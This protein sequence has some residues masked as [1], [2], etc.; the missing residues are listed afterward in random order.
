LARLAFDLLILAALCK[1]LD[2]LARQGVLNT[3]MLSM[4]LVG[5]SFFLGMAPGEVG[6]VGVLRHPIR[7]LIRSGI[8]VVSLLI[9]W[10]LLWVSGAWWQLGVLYIFAILVYALGRW[11]GL[12]WK[13]LVT[14]SLMLLVI[15]FLWQFSGRR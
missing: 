9:Y 2:G 5:L 13:G 10:Q 14:V 7:G 15:Y 1:E 11:A 3:G 8:A 12:A 4:S 6:F